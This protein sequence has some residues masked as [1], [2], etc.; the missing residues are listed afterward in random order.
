MQ[1]V[2]HFLRLLR[3]PNLIFI[4]I[5][6]VL[7]HFCI[8]L[9]AANGQTTFFPLQLQQVYFWTICVAS[10]FI[11]GAGYII[12][13]Y[14]DINIDE[15]NKPDKMIVDKIISRRAAIFWHWLFSGIG[16]LLSAYVSFKLRNP[17]IIIGNTLCVLLLWVYS[18]TYKRRLL[19]GNVLIS[20]MTAWVIL[21]MLVAELPGWL[22]GQINEAIEKASAAR[23]SRIGVL[24]AAFAFVL[25]LV[26]EVIKDMEDMEGDL[27]EHCRTM[28]IVYGINAA[29][30]FAGTW[31]FILIT[32][33]IITQV[34][35]LLFGWW[36]SA[37]YIVMLVVIPLIL[38]FRNLFRA[39]T[40][41]AFHKL[42]SQLKW[43][44]LT[45]I[46]SMLFFLLYTR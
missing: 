26:R 37:L 15:V 5:T 3:W 14:F 45:G 39:N 24:Y 2:G 4:A 13:D 28:P 21:V 29:K 32:M 46:F 35:V 17:L 6:Q 8:V 44:M 22:T 12:N 7:F 27:K 11:A 10:V 19:I 16:L 18:T 43:V 33:L 9:P 42:S 41:A 36:Y 30:V 1:L 20:L 38:L 25:S 40:V 34:Y 23:L 31:L